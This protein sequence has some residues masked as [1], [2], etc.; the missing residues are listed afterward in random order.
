MEG[1]GGFSMALRAALAT[2]KLVNTLNM[3][4]EPQ[5]CTIY[6]TVYHP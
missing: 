6:N 1:T 5:S 3:R 4:R 2:V